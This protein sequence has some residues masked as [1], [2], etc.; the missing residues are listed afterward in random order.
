MLKRFYQKSTRPACRIENRL[1][2]LRISDLNHKSDHRSRRVELARVTGCVTH[3]AQ[4]RFVERSKRV[5][6]FA[7][8][9]MDSGNFVDHV[10]QEIAID[11]AIDRAFENSR[12]H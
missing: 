3:L 4:H 11:H 9:K 5:Q 8:T 10:A 6:L 12:D 2:E 1:A 7:R